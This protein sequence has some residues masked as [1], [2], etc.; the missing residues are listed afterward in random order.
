M[1][2][3][4]ILLVCSALLTLAAS[5][6]T[7]Q[8]SLQA[9]PMPVQEDTPL[10]RLSGSGRILP[11]RSML[12]GYPS[13]DDPVFWNDAFWKEKLTQWSEEG[14]NTLIWYGP[15]ELTNGQHVL[16]KHTA[17]PEARELTLVESDR[18]IGRM[19]HL[20]QTT[21]TLGLKNFLLTQHL[22]YTA[23]FAKA[24]GLAEPQTVSPQVST[25]HNDG[26]PDFWRGGVTVNCGIR[27]ALTLAY[28]EAL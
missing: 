2:R 10:G 18:R 9:N 25:W 21:R 24:H 14:Y 15:N 13:P 26:Y 27:N 8:V 22:F 17:F 28:T 5:A 7:M 20:F 3:R 16:A 11:F 1:L 6:Q 12:V 23:A 19:N 4:I